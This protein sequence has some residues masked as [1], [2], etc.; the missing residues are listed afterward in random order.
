MPGTASG[1]GLAVSGK[2]GSPVRY[3]DGTIQL[4]WSDLVSTGFGTPWGQTRNWTN[5]AGYA[6]PG[7]NGTGMVD[8]QV[9]Y[10]M[11][12]DGSTSNTIVLIASGTDA[13][14]FD[15]N[16][17]VYTSRFFSQNQLSYDAGTDTWTFT[18]TT[19]NRIAFEGFG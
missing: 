6:S 2:S 5:G 17:S 9:P 8:T 12:A 14:Y 18:D 16:G 4:A 19:G 15:Y 3:A 1:Q 10:L 13:E 7:G 11:Q